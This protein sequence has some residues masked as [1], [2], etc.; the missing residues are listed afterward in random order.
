MVELLLQT[1]L[2]VPPLRP[3]I[4]PCSCLI[5]KLKNGLGGKLTLISDPAG[6]GKTILIAAGLPHPAWLSLDDKDNYPGRY[7]VYVFATLKNIW[8][9]LDGGLVIVLQSPQPH[10]W[11]P[12]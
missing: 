11:I 9:E 1:K 12:Y 4:V 8:N 2:Y 10:T 6:F 3:A 5:K 7:W